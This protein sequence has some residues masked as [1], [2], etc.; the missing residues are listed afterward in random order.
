MKPIITVS[1]LSKRY[2]IGRQ[3]GKYVAMRD[4]LGDALKNPGHLI[5]SKV[6][7]LTG[8]SDK[9][10]FLALDDVSFSVN[11]GDAVGIIGANGSGKSTLLKILTRITAPTKGEIR[12]G[13]K[14]SS[15]LEVG[16][17]FHPELTGR[18]NIYLN[19]AILGMTQKEIQ[20]QFSA[21][22][23]FS[24][25]EKFI[26]TP[27]KHYSSGMYV[28]LA[29]AVAAH[30][31]PDILLVDEVLAVGD[32][33]FQKKC[34]GKM[35]EVTKTGGR[36]ILFVS[37]NMTAVQNLCNKC[38]YLEKGKVKAYGKTKMVLD[39]YMKSTLESG[40]SLG[41]R[42]DRK[43][44]GTVRITSFHI[45]RSGKKVTTLFP[46][47]SYNFCFSYESSINQ[48]IK[49]AEFW[50]TIYHESGLALVQLDTKYPN[51]DFK[52]L[53]PR[54]TV[55]CAIEHLPLVSGIYQFS[56][57]VNCNQGVDGI[58]NAGSFEVK[59]GK[60]FGPHAIVEQGQIYLMQKWT[61]S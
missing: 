50:S 8:K 32:A 9:G 37:H 57:A 43:T 27:V 16:T 13:G 7:E 29:F 56:A 59:A 20:K 18:E 49:N 53:P 35:D 4:I 14:V 28:R 48:P 51:Q 33:A 40:L 19:G 52:Q 21:I 23:E 1:H 15:L 45:E 31:E 11:H 44:K 6:D 25:V 46:G 61:S 42:Q 5:K 30:M 39:L 36:T 54:G 58:K 10:S 3:R 47:G 24:G 22:V 2:E 12:L 60:Y 17:G 26:D 38:V 34:L 55:K 41:D